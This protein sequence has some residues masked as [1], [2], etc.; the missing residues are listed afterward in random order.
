[1]NLLIFFFIVK[2]TFNKELIIEIVDWESNEGML[3][4]LLV[5]KLRISFK[6][7]NKNP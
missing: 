6:I 4:T 1:M 5:N 2:M 3:K 7:V